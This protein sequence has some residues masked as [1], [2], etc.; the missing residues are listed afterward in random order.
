MSLG[1]ANAGEVYDWQML[2]LPKVEDDACPFMV[3]ICGTTTTGTLIGSAK[4]IQG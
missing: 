4:L 3:M 2:G 1:N